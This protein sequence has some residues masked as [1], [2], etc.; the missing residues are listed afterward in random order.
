MPCP[1]KIT[2]ANLEW[3]DDGMPY[4]IDYDDVYFSRDDAEGESRHVFLDGNRLRSRWQSL[5]PGSRFTIGEL[6]F[7]SGLN[8]MQ[9]LR[10]WQELPT[11]DSRLHYIAFEQ[12]PL[13]HADMLRLH[14]RWPDCAEIS[15]R[16]LQQ[17]P[18]HTAG[19]HRLQLAANVILDLYYGD[20]SAQL[21]ATAAFAHCHIDCWYLDGFSPARNPQLWQ[22]QLLA[23][24]A[25]LSS[26]GTT[27]S[28]YSVA[29]AVRQ[30]L[31]AAGFS[32]QK[33]PG[34]GRKREMLYATLTQPEE[35]AV[36]A[37]SIKDFYADAPWLRLP[38]AVAPA[39]QGHAIVIG[40]GLA[41]CSTARS[42]AARGW[43]VTV[44]ERGPRAASGAAAIPQ[45]ALRCRLFKQA[46]AVAEFF[47]QAFVFANRQFSY[48][49]TGADISW[50]PTGVVQLAG[51]L[52]RGNPLAS[53]ALATIYS[54]Q[55]IAAV[56]RAQAGTLAGLELRAD[57][58]WLPLGGWL[59]AATLCASYLEHPA[60]TLLTDC[61]VSAI[62][63]GDIGTWEVCTTAANYSGDIVVIANGS[64]A[65]ALGQCDYLPLHDVRGQI[66]QVAESPRSGHLSTVV[67]GTRTI[68]P[69]TN[70]GVHT[71]AASYATTD[72]DTQ[73]FAADDLANL[74]G[75]ALNFMEQDVLD[76]TI[77]ANVVAMRCNSSDRFP[78]VGRLADRAAT[79][80]ALA[81]LG[82]NARHRFAATDTLAAALYYPGLY[83]NVAHG[84]N[85]LAT[86]P[87]S[88]ELLASLITNENLPCTDAI[89][90]N[91]NPIRF[92][93]RE[94]KQQR[95]RSPN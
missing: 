18:D 76:Q 60:I 2:N 5:L 84:S 68:F 58:W 93:I 24:I 59:Q 13:T 35:P 1:M 17:Y 10:L 19:C 44:L 50:H 88:A 21:S 74:S 63:P 36:K 33:L 32:V 11:Q 29:G 56:S 94:L 43:R 52:N 12:H 3:R 57:G 55:I 66:T 72:G 46:D 39:T 91:L 62:L 75:A 64:A 78:V 6:G 47:T 80:A 61:A 82:R 79:L 30:K 40:A 31:A 20:A 49:Q 16:L 86:C 41:G 26:H 87:F 37:A 85:G 54:P 73:A 92:L 34:F 77:T 81:A 67:N 25:A 48:L 71:L 23:R 65:R 7:G 83:V 22:P 14:G 89:M 95:T 28:S 9:T 4:A 42:L 8:F 38:A 70:S 53:A 27:L 51:A 15:Q 90:A 69:A 45:M